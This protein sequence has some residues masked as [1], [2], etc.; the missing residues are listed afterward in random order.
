VRSA[1]CKVEWE[2]VSE[3]WLLVAPIVDCAANRSSEP[4]LVTIRSSLHFALG[5]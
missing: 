1:K 4:P 5:T 3:E 2:V